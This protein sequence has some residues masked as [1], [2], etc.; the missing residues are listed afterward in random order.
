M[1]VARQLS[2]RQSTIQAKMLESGVMIPPLIALV[3]EYE[4]ER[5]SAHTARVRAIFRLN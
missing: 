5:P 4:L 2:V 1:S 3:L